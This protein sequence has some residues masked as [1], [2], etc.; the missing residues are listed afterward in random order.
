[1]SIG[2]QPNQLES[3]RLNSRNTA[4]CCREYLAIERS[5]PVHV[6]AQVEHQR[7]SPLAMARS[8]LEISSLKQ[9]T[10]FASRCPLP[11]QPLLEQSTLLRHLS[12]S[13]QTTERITRTTTHT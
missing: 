10:R 11:S 13:L 4:R 2:E 9:L 3:N 5:S 8:T 6:R 7:G 12:R 1:M